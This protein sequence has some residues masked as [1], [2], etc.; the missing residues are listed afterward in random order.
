MCCPLVHIQAQ[1]GTKHIHTVGPS[2]VPV[3]SSAAP[4][5]DSPIDEC[6]NAR[7]QTKKKTLPANVTSC[8]AK[9]KHELDMLIFYL[10][11]ASISCVDTIEARQAPETRCVYATS[12]LG[13]GKEEAACKS[14][15]ASAL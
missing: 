11:L 3:Y 4:S 5:E 15:S 7:K 14:D 1:P 9:K 13:A 12:A 8:C 6:K 2:P 10:W